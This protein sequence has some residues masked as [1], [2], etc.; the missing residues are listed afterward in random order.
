M[1]ND[2]S[3]V[4]AFVLLMVMFVVYF[5][6]TFIA[7]RRKHPN[8][9]PI[10]LV[11]LLLGWTALG[12]VAALIWSVSSIKKD[13]A[14]QVLQAAPTED[15]YEKLETLASLKERGLLSEQE[16]EIEKGKLLNS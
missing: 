4:A 1:P 2:S 9:T 14:P 6:P 8:G 11:N 5:L 15:K 7:A 3:P 10:F 12:W 13:Q 16:Y